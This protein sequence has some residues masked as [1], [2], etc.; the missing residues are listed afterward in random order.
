MRKTIIITVIFLIFLL[1]YFLQANLFTW[2]NIAGIM[3]NM[4][5][6]FVLFIGLFTNKY[7]GISTGI[8]MGILIDT[9]IGRTYGLTSIMLGTIG[10]LGGVLEKTFSKDSRITIMLMVIAS[11]IIY[12]ARNI[13]NRSNTTKYTNRTTYIFKNTNN[14]NNIQHHNNNNNISTTT[15][16]RILYRRNI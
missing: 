11:T 12:E 8:I 1:I 14:R 15:K 4:F 3:P 9:F 10:F 16:R 13:S 7:I 6:I 2:F 5:V